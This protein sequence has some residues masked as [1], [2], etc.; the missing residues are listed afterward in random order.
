[1]SYAMSAALQRAVFQQLGTLDT[2]VFDAVPAGAVPDLYI[3]IGPEEARD[4]SD[5]TGAG[6]VHLFTVTVFSTAPSFAKAKT[7][8][9][10]ICDLLASPGPSLE[11]GKLITMR[12]VRARARRVNQAGARQIDLRFRARLEDG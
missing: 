1:M 6:A 10:Q 9:A 5:K 3:S 7:V 12:F 8:A 4:A 2:P 11:R